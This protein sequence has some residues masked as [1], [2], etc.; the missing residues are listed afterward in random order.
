MERDP[1]TASTSR[2]SARR[3]PAA[4]LSARVAAA[5]E[6]TGT[7]I[8]P[9]AAIVSRCTI[10]PTALASTPWASFPSGR[11][12]RDGP[13]PVTARVAPTIRAEKSPAA[14]SP[15]L[16]PTAQPPIESAISA[17]HRSP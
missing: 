8:E 5:I 6:T 2:C 11:G 7:H 17:N 14:V 13:Q 10:S 1:V 4:T 16:S 12:T 9:R 15:T 3:A